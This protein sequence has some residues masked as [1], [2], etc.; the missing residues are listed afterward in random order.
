MKMTTTS[1]CGSHTLMI[2]LLLCFVL[3]FLIQSP[4]TG[5]DVVD[6]DFSELLSREEMVQ[7]A[8]YG[9]EKLSTVLVTGSVHCEAHNFHGKADHQLHAWPIPGAL[10]AVNCHSHGS[11]RREKSTVAQGVTDE[12][13]EFMIDLPSYLHAIPN[14]EK[15]CRVRVHQIPKNSKCQPDNVNK[16]LKKLILSTFGNGIRTY[17]AGNLR[18][19]HSNSKP[20]HA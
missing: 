7:M 14:L 11:E 19:Q 5:E 12:Y 18:F 6:G 4:V 2:L 1:F 13:G 9:E 16:R 8:G 10:V 3:F 15:I 17:S 20:L